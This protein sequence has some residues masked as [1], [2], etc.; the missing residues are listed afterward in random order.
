M[1]PSWI[2]RSWR[3]GSAFGIGIY[4]HWSLLLVP[5][6]ILISKGLGG[7]L[8]LVPF[9]LLLVTGVF[10]CVVLH[11]LGHALMA[12]HFGIGT[13]SIT[14]YP[15]GGIA[16]LERLPDDPAEEVCIALAGP[17]VNFA[18]ASVLYALFLAIAGVAAL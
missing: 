5:L 11:E 3:V 17:A 15:I 1:R 9:L 16:G 14:L 2:W 7:S 10:T 8:A 12:R 6:F 4:L 13:R 18:I